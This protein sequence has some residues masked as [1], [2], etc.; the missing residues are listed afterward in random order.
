MIILYLQTV[1]PVCL[2][3]VRT[4]LPGHS[5]K[6]MFVQLYHE[7]HPT[8]KSCGGKK[9]ADMMSCGFPVPDVSKA[10]EGFA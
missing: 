6:S 4:N 1:S 9:S 3:N 5:G 2:S 10:S 7:T 8:C